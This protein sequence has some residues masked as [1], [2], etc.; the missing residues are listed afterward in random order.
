MVNISQ[1]FNDLMQLI[2][3]N[4]YNKTEADNKYALKSDIPS[5]STVDSSLSTSSEHPVQNKVVKSALDG[6][7]DIAQGSGN[8]GKNVVT[9]NNGDIGLEDKPSIPSASNTLPSSDTLNGEVGTGVTWARSNHKHPK[10]DLYAEANHTHNYLTSADITGKQDTSNLSND[11]STDAS[12][13]TK[14]PS[15]NAIKGYVDSLVSSSVS[16]SVI[17][18]FDIGDIEDHEMINIDDVQGGLSFQNYCDSEGITLHPNVI[19]LVPNQLNGTE[20]YYEFLVVDDGNDG[21]FSEMIGTTQ[22][23][24]S[25]YVTITGLSSNLQTI[26][27]G[28]INEAQQQ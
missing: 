24:L 16:I 15:V 2:G 17:D 8:G 21:V 28:L 20:F 25:N 19:Y 27:Q 7:V 9:D 10:S 23:D 18:D 22:V 14:Y 13:T 6:K 12:S 11:I 26:V 4:Y 1:L 3:L 5:S